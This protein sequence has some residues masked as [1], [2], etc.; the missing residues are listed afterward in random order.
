MGDVKKVSARYL[1]GDSEVSSE[2][3]RQIVERTRK[4]MGGLLGA[5]PAGGAAFLERFL[6]DFSPE[7][8]TT[9]AKMD[10]SLSW[11]SEDAKSWNKYKKMVEDQK[12][13]VFEEK[14]YEAIARKAEALM[15]GTARKET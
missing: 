13:Q 12:G 8:V 15:G 2:Q 3:L 11:G 10:K 9:L 5:I 14:M 4:V 6:S 7:K 1:H